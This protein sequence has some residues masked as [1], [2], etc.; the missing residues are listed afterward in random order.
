MQHRA[1]SA[2]TPFKFLGDSPIVIVLKHRTLVSQIFVHLRLL[3]CRTFSTLYE[4]VRHCTY[5][6]FDFEFETSKP[7]VCVCGNFC[8]NRC[9]KVFSNVHAGACVLVR[10]CTFLSVRTC[11]MCADVRQTSAC[12]FFVKKSPKNLDF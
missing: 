4:L 11:G 9:G 10:A 1:S 2:V 5:I 8:A 7:L 3:F 6:G 12:L